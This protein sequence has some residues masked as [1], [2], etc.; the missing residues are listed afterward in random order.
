MEKVQE[1]IIQINNKISVLIK[2]YRSMKLVNNDLFKK[3]ESLLTELK[4]KGI[5]IKELE[6]KIK[7]LKIVEN[8]SYNDKDKQQMK[9]QINGY[10]KEIDK[11]IAM[12]NS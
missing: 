2:K 9:Q 4:L 3:N 5:K 10:V 12:L 8:L 7:M 11:C 1:K 6:N